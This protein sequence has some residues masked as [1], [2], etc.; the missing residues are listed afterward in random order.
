MNIAASHR[1]LAQLLD[2]NAGF[3]LDARG[4]TDHCPMALAALAQM[5]ASSERLGAF[6]D[7]WTGTYS[8][9]ETQPDTA[10]E[11]GN[12]LAQL[13]N[14]AAF[15]SLRRHFRESIEEQGAS[16]MIADV[17]GHAPFAPAT[18]AF[19]AIIRT[20]YGI[21]AGHGG[22]I[23]AGLAAYAATN[24]P[25]P[26]EW[27]G[28]QPALSVHHGLAILSN[29]FSGTRWPDG[30]I[31][32]R[33]KAIAAN[34]DFREALPAPPEAA[35]LLDDMARNAIGLYWQTA[36]FTVLH[37]VTG[38]HAARVLL[39]QLPA[40]LA[41]PFLASTWAAF[42]A[43]YVSAGAP[44]PHPADPPG[45]EARWP[46]VLRLAIG[47]DDDHVIKMAYTCFQEHLRDRGSP[48]YLAAASRIVR[49]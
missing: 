47:S 29:R 24:L 3:A 7:R 37:M 11:G 27:N 43:A 9:I 33:L 44:A 26:Y 12:W 45:L 32:G 10:L 14:P 16:K 34:A 2:A 1:T 15:N 19:H 25:I 31:T 46:E 6:F 18:G 13:G 4:T 39:A 30:S 23:A 48:Y 22:E 35:S 8:I 21:E 49:R 42:C 41:H 40:G 36:D 5:G 17:V 38:M 28:R 20:A